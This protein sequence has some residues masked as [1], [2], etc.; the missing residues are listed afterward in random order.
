SD[1]DELEFDFEDPPE[2]AADAGHVI[3]ANGSHKRV[4]DDGDD[5][6][7]D[8]DNEE[9]EEDEDDDSSASEDEFEAVEFSNQIDFEK[10]MSHGPAAAA[11]TSASDMQSD[12]LQSVVKSDSRK[13]LRRQVHIGDIDLLER[14][15]DEHPSLTLHLFDSHFRFDGQEGVFLY[16]G[17]MRFFF[18]ALNEGKI[19]IDLVDVLAQV[20]CRYYE[21]CLIV[22]VRDH[23]R[24]TL[25]P[26]TKKQRVTDL[27]T[28]SAFGNKQSNGANG[29]LSPTEDG[30]Y[31][32]RAQQ[33]AGSV[34]VYKKVMRPTS[35]TVN[36]DIQL[37]CERSRTK[38]TQDDVLEMEGMILLA[39]EEP[40]DLEPDFQ[41]SR[42]SNAIRYIEYGHL[43]PRKQRKYNSAEVEAEKAER[44]EKLK[45]LT[46][47]DDRKNREFQP[48][49][50]RVSQ[51]NEWRHKKYVND[52]EPYPAAVPASVAGKKTSTKKSRSQLSLMPDGRKVIR[53]LRFV[54]TINGQS[55]H[56]VFHVLELPDGKGLQGVMRWG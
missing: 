54:Q 28:S 52:A 22:E 26:K 9:D 14:Y 29:S 50:N 48:S 21:G 15:K 27:L 34:K 23:R 30:T 4:I 51:V 24:P 37:V 1:D 39:I 5:E 44:E 53:T 16:N 19:P 38:L 31:A 11:A 49:F 47:M 3:S 2:N 56:T 18:E 17:P 55:T 10:S 45:L 32:E 20:N 41:V 42:V 35:E 7:G 33:D 25:E 43:L 46:L 13:R 36:L 8:D 12:S 40:L 6:D